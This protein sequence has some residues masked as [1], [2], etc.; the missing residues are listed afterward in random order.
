MT[1]TDPNDP[2]D[3]R[4][5]PTRVYG[6]RG[7]HNTSLW[8][9]GALAMLAILGVLIYAI[10]NTGTQTASNTPGATTGTGP[11]TAGTEKPSQPTATL[12][13]PKAPAAPASNR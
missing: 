5:P 2:N 10:A 9:V 12:P 11:S 4:L 7:A 8:V 1:Y 13:N 6:D 3:L